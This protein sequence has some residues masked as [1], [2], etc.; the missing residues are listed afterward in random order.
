MGRV[1]I[2][3]A[4]FVF[5][6]NLSPLLA[7]EDSKYYAVQFYADW[8]KYCKKLGPTFTELLNNYSDEEIEYVRLDFTDKETQEATKETINTLGLEKI[9]KD[10]VGTG[11]IL[12]VERDSEGV[13]K[14]KDIL[15]RKK[16]L[17]EMKKI[18]DEL[19]L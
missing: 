14:V 1:K 17:D 4:G 8:C 2:F 11:F 6:L 7:Q 10:Y 3:L 15:D 16:D 12:V 13:S 19:V 9:T 5:L 18:V